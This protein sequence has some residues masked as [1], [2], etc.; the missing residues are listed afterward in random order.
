MRTVSTDIPA[1]R[2]PAGDSSEE[3]P[4][5]LREARERS[6]LSLRQLAKRL[7]I[8]ASALSQIETGKSRPSVR[9]LYAVVSEL[10]ISLDELFDHQAP[11][12]DAHSLSP[13]TNTVVTRGGAGAEWMLAG[14]AARPMLRSG[15]RP[16]LDLDSGVQWERLTAEHDPVIDFLHVTY[17]PGGASNANG[18]LVRHAGREY[19]IV[20]SGR[21]DVTVGFETYRLGPGDSISFSSDEPHLLANTSAEP[22]T[23]IWFFVGRRA[24]DPRNPAFA[25]APPAGSD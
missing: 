3:M 18:A 17:E 6:G 20:L 2:D 25:D 8:S 1:P 22:A 19:G 13:D 5:R 24:T 7:D 11:S 16:H 21:L 4:R 15:E 23:G 12:T 10:G 14:T 9:T